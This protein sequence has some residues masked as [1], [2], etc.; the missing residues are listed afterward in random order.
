VQS[1]LL[2]RAFLLCVAQRYGDDVAGALAVEQWTG[3]AG[4][5]AQ[6]LRRA[7][8][9]DGDDIAAV[10]KIFQ[11]H[12]AFHPRTYV[13]WRVEITGTQRAR[14]T[15]GDC[16]ARREGD[17]YS[18]FAHLGAAPHPALD[19]IAAAGNLRA[20]CRPVAAEA[21]GALAWDV[22]IDPQAEPLAEPLEMQLVKMST[23]ASI[24]FERRRP[25]RS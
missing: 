6:R 22:V 13:D 15:L 9:I 4:V 16:P 18:W 14:L 24:V 19:V 20:R 3:I 11:V 25:L 10:A 23:G 5:T 17:P 7:L 12:P 2:A 8:E 1:H 21:A